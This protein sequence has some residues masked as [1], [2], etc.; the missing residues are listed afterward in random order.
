MTHTITLSRREFGLLNYITKG[1]YNRLD[2]DVTEWGG[3]CTG[4]DVIEH[5]YYGKDVIKSLHLKTRD[6]LQDCYDG[7]QEAV[8]LQKKWDYRGVRIK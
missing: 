4:H 8:Q 2:S 5:E 6:I 7:N 3:Q 1:L